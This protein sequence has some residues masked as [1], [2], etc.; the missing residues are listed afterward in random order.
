M[1][2]AQLLEILCCPETRQDVA[3]APDALN[4]A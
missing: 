3:V 2:D 1:I 4:A